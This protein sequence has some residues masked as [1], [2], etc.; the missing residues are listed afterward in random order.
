M[1]QSPTNIVEVKPV[2]NI[3]TV[4]I[5]IALLALAV[6]V[7]VVGYRL[8]GAKGYGMKAGDMFSP[9]AAAPVDSGSVSE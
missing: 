1:S 2:A 3:Y 8:M 9:P 7:G 5:L 6:S 4:L